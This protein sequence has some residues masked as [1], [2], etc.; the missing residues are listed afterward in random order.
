MPTT[1]SKPDQADEP[2]SAA[3][4]YALPADRFTEARNGLVKR[5]R[6]GGDRDEASRVAKLRR[7][8]AAAWALNQV[9]REQPDLVV[10][11]LDSGAALKAAM[12]AA[13]SGDAT[14]LRPAQ[15]GERA[16]VDA[17]LGAALAHLGS[18][19]LAAGDQ[20]RQR[21]AA[22]LRAAVVDATV[23]AELEAGSLDRDHDLPGFG[24]DAPEVVAPARPPV[25]P[26][27]AAALS[28]A[29][30]AGS[31]ADAAVAAVAAGRPAGAAPTR[32]RPG[33][34]PRELARR[35]ALVEEADRLAARA[36]ELDSAAA[37]AEE[38]ARRARRT[39]D[40]AAADA[41]S[42]RRRADAANRPGG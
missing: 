11:V 34:S 33:T 28:E 32:R 20:A 27:G 8:S 39:A 9:A 14:G 29:A 41:A 37:A 24:L 4:L 21:L 22:T 16:A 25:A 38:A 12:E 40:R 31:P 3:D 15:A 13:L 7:P 1:T 10:A 30:A 36:E 19:G 23:A 5:L 35:S 2:A 26:A 17:A 42:A 18:A 6:A